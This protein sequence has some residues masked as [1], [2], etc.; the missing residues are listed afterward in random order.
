[1]SDRCREPVGAFYP[2]LSGTRQSTC[3]RKA[4]RDGFCKQHHPETKAARNAEGKAYW[5][6]RMAEGRKR[7]LAEKVG[8]AV[9]DLLADE[10]EALPPSIRALLEGK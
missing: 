4:V 3:L 1:M 10:Q 9:F 5:D 6:A 7:I 2:T 8:M